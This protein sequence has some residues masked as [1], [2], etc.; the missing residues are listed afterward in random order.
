MVTRMSW[1]KLHFHQIAF[2]EALLPTIWPNSQPCGWIALQS[3]L[4]H[5]LSL[6]TTFL[7]TASTC[8]PCCPQTHGLRCTATHLW[9]ALFIWEPFKPQHHLPN[10]RSAPGYSIALFPL[11]CYFL[12]AIFF[13]QIALWPLL[14]L[15]ARMADLQ[16][17]LFTSTVITSLLQTLTSHYTPSDYPKHVTISKHVLISLFTLLFLLYGMPF[18]VFG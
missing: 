8:L 5:H 9:M 3:E 10:T 16:S 13:K 15:I 7:Q 4:S 14:L 1:L 18:T 6:P 17:P 2:P 12:C 11:D